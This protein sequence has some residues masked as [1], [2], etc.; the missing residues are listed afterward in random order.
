VDRDYRLLPIAKGGLKIIANLLNAIAW[1]NFALTY[2]NLKS[3]L[4]L[5]GYKWTNS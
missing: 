1:G 4:Y 3:N 2:K 5:A